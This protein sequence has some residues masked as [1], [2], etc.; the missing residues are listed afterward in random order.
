M[1][2]NEFELKNMEQKKYSNVKTSPQ[3]VGLYHYYHTDFYYSM[4]ELNSKYN[5]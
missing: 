4:P 5:R 3:R 1:E 2:N